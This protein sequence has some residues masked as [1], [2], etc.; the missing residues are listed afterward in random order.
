MTRIADGL[1]PE[2][3]EQ[4]RLDVS[5]STQIVELQVGPAGVLP[6]VRDAATVGNRDALPPI[7]TRDAAVDNRGFDSRMNSGLD[8]G[9]QVGNPPGRE[10]RALSV[11]S[12]GGCITTKEG[13][14]PFWFLAV[15]LLFGLRKKSR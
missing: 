4:L 8:Q 7:E 1:I 14:S 10:P 9:P 12:V 13:R 11:R 2:N 15:L 6:T 3:I 5:G